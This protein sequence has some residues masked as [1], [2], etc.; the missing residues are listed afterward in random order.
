[1]FKKGTKLYSIANAKCPKCHE[2]DFFEVANPYKNPLKAGIVKDSCNVCGQKYHIEPGFYY[3][4]MYVSYALGVAIFV[5]VFIAAYVLW[6]SAEFMDYV[7]LIGG[8]MVALVPFTYQ[9]SKI[10]WGNFFIHYD[11]QAKNKAGDLKK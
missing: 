8:I 7:Y 6:P 1:M 11:E 5:A 2:G 3:G 9:V 10:I 4:A